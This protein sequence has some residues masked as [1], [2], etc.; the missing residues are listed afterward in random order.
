MARY[1]RLEDIKMKP[2]EPVP[3][4]PQKRKETYFCGKCERYH[5]I[6]S[7]IGNDHRDYKITKAEERYQ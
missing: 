3:I 4:P 2:K 7:D 1:F 5:Y 6:Y